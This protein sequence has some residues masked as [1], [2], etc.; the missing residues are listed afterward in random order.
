MLNKTPPIGAPKVAA[1]PAATEAPRIYMHNVSFSLICLKASNLVIL[2]AIIPEMCTNGPSLPID[3]P[4][5]LAAISPITFAMKV[6][7]VKYFYKLTPASIDFISGIPDPSASGVINC[8]TPAAIVPKIKLR[9]IQATKFKKEFSVFESVFLK[10]DKN[11]EDTSIANPNNA[12]VIPRIIRKT[13]TDGFSTGY[14][15]INYYH[16][17]K[18]C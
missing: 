8:P 11:S 3:K 4:A 16:L 6:L 10:S 14:V 2:F 5:P 7:K 18:L 13:H 9:P 1:T 17:L 12:E 15:L